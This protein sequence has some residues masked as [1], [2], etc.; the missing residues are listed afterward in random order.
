M[1][2][3]FSILI[4]FNLLTIS[5]CAKRD[6]PESHSGQTQS[7]S[8]S[9]NSKKH[10]HHI[11]SIKPNTHKKYKGFELATVPNQF[12]GTW[13]RG[14]TY[15]KK[16]TKLVITSHIVNN[17]VAYH[18]VDTNL[19][20]NHNSVKQNKKYTGNAVVISTSANRLKVHGF[21][22]TV[23]LIYHPDTFK[24]QNC[25]YLSYGTN[26]TAINGCIFQNRQ[27]AIK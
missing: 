12:Q 14:N 22:D 25:L 18:Q 7:S 17:S 2:K 9:V 5:A 21:F 13:Y 1:K 23:D 10:Y 20:L 6:K 11:R 15:E 4:L 8:I 19:K 24:R 26:P 3:L 27:A 16:I